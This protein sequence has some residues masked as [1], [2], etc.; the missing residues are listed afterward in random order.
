M[1]NLY[2]QFKSLIPE[3]PLQVGTVTSIATNMAI[4]QLP[5]GDQIT[6]RGSAQIGEK[7]FITNGVIEG[8][9]PNLP[10]DIIEI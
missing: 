1:P 2:E 5:G 7:V 6:A 3:H 10:I 4:V 8:P 9:A